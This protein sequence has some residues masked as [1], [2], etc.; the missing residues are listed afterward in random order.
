MFFN[1]CSLSKQVNAMAAGE[2]RLPKLGDSLPIT[3][4][5]KEAVAKIGCSEERSVKRRQRDQFGLFTVRQS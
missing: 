5:V 4:E 1:Y 3:L 2:G